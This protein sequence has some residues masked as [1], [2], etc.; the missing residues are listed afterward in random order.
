[1]KKLACLLAGAALWAMPAGA[2]DLTADDFEAGSVGSVVKLCSAPESSAMN[3]YAQGFCYGWI[4]GIEQ[5][6]DALVADPRFNV[7]PSI[8]TDGEISR[9][10]A[11]VML[12]SWAAKNPDSMS[13]PALSGLIQAIREQN[14]C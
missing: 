4:A 13:M 5:F 7:Q 1:M 6:Y 12:L 10:E 14:P 3:Q 9:E 8:C 2:A 11:R